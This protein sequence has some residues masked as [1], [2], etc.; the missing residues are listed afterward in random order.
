MSPDLR[1]ASEHLAGAD[2]A[3]LAWRVIEPAYDAVSIYDGPEALAAPLR[4]LTGG[5]RALLALH[6]CVSE[7]LNGGLDQFFANPSG[8]LADE[9]RAAFERIGVPAAATLLEEAGAIF[10]L[11]PAAPDPDDPGFDEAD[12]AG[13]F[14]AYR[15]RYEPLEERFYALVDTVIYPHA[16]AYVRAHPAEFTR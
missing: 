7:T 10:A 16:A 6:W 13:E 1:V 8:L 5:Q 11:R 9:A 14:D 15:E 12:D 4:E 2:D 3:D